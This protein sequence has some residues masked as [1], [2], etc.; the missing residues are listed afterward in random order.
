MAEVTAVVNLKFHEKRDKNYRG[1]VATAGSTKPN[2]T[3][4]ANVPSMHC[5]SS[6]HAAHSLRN[7]GFES[8][9]KGTRPLRAG[10]AF[11]SSEEGLISGLSVIMASD[12]IMRSNSKT[13]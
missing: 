8:V 9:S 13:T 1:M 12:Y 6:F 2:L 3:V 5:H 7:L 10:S 11:I 4:P